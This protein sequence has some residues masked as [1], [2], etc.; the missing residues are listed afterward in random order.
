MKSFISFSVIVIWLFFFPLQWV[1]NQVNHNRMA[2]VDDIVYT[3]AQQARSEGMFTTDNIDSMVQ[4]IS[5]ETGVPVAE[6]IVSVD[7]GM[8]YRFNDF[9][10]REMIS[11]SISIPVDKIIAMHQILGI[12]DADNEM[13]Y[14][15]DGQV[16]SEVLA[17]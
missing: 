16:P 14:V 6:I 5:V 10:E 1:A 3:Y 4:K 2:T 13:L 12:S 7:S 17:P 8:K 15:V 11:Y 9:R